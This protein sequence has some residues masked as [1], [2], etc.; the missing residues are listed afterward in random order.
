MVRGLV[1]AEED[2]RWLDTPRCY[3]P[4]TRYDGARSPGDA[5]VKP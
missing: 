3:G 1:I 2:Q 5:D 4:A